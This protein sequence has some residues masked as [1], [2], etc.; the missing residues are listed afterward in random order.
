MKRAYDNFWANTNDKNHHI[1]LP[2]PTHQ[3]ADQLW[4]SRYSNRS[5]VSVT[6][7]MTHVEFSEEIKTEINNTLPNSKIR[8]R[9]W[10]KEND[11]YEDIKCTSR[12][13][14]SVHSRLD[15]VAQGRKREEW[16]R[17]NWEMRKGC[18]AGS[19]RKDDYLVKWSYLS[20]LVSS[21][22]SFC[23]N[24]VKQP[25]LSSQYCRVPS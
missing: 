5:G 17:R 24:P 6:V 9:K 21:R 16:T 18:F 25:F 13:K 3:C 23:L 12:Y 20:T 1:A 8:S 2:Y 14:S 10:T 4:R 22:S 15:K 19:R 7:K 11:K